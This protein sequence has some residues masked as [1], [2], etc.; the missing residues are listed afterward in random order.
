MH[1]T[2]EAIYTND[3]GL[4]PEGFVAKYGQQF[5]IPWDSVRF[6]GAVQR[7]DA[8]AL[9]DSFF[10][11]IVSSAA[12]QHF[13]IP[14]ADELP[15]DPDVRAFEAELHARGLLPSELPAKSAWQIAEADSTYL[16]VCVYPP[17]CSG[18][19]LYGVETT[20]RFPFKRSHLVLAV[21]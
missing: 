15:D 7:I 10:W 21:A 6:V 14:T 16:S 13:W 17:R 9:S 19:P 11:A 4:T 12:D 3:V 18:I 5:V 1:R 8:V 2:F 20:R